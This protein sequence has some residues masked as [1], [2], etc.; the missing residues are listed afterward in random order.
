MRFYFSILLLIGIAF[1]FQNCGKPLKIEEKV[2]PSDI[3]SSSFSIIGSQKTSLEVLEGDDVELYV[4]I[5]EG[6][7]PVQ[8]EWRKQG[9]DAILSTAKHF[10]FIAEL[11]DSGFYQA[12]VFD[13]DSDALITFQLSVLN[14]NLESFPQISPQTVT[15]FSKKEGESLSLVLTVSGSPAPQLQWYKGLPT[16]SGQAIVGQN[17]N[18]LTLSN[19]KLDQAGDY[20]LQ[21]T[22][23]LGTVLSQKFSL[24]ITVPSSYKGSHVYLGGTGKILKFYFDAST[25]NISSSQTYN[26]SGGSIGSI[27][28]LEDRMVAVSRTGNALELYSLANNFSLSSIKSLGFLANSVHI[29]FSKEGNKYLLFGSSYTNAQASYFSAD[30]KQLTG[31][32]ERKKITYTTGLKTHSSS[33][34][35]SLKFLFVSNLGENKVQIYRVTASDLI[36]LGN[37]SVTSPR[38]VYYDETYQLLYVVTEAAS[39]NGFIKIYEVNP[40][41]NNNVSVLEKGSYSFGLNGSDLKINHSKNFI[42]A[43]VREPGAEKLVILPLSATGQIDSARTPFVY[44]ITIPAPRSLSVSDNGMYFFVTTSEFNSPSHLVVYKA[45]Y[46]NSMQV[47]GMQKITQANTVSD[48]Y[49]CNYSL[50][51]NTP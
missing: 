17:S 51:D 13:Q 45:T 25:E 14:K 43:M 35:T 40:M 30:D 21:A 26:F 28:H 7:F 39:Q 12:K 4:D 3:M 18:T 5:H 8:V 47:T 31:Y 42:S 50:D 36:S 38:N 23:K 46:N 2:L 41:G 48:Y 11:S 15:Q 34:S 49:Y 16:N 10:H 19:L 44:P 29:N 1:L 37:I 24:E 32:A 22:N 6:Q 33:Y 9:D 20:Y 27:A